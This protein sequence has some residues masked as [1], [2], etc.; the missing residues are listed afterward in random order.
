M[1]ALDE[2]EIGAS[3]NGQN[4]MRQHL[5]MTNPV[6]KIYR[7]LLPAVPK[8][9]L[10]PACHEFRCSSLFSLSTCCERL[11]NSNASGALRSRLDD[12]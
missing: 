6:E 8:L 3:R 4:S 12:A 1:G 7:A 9:I 10:L 2:R 5:P 11:F